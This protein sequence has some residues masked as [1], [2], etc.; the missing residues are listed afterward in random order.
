MATRKETLIPHIK[1]Q[2]LDEILG[3]KCPT[4]GDVFR[5][6]FFL[7][8]TKNLSIAEA[9]KTAVNAAKRFWSEAG[10]STKLEMF[11]IRDLISIWNDY[12]VNK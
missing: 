9:Q 6:F 3:A 8:K 10:V 11:A 4:R 7:R 12:Q 5:H 1:E 2:P